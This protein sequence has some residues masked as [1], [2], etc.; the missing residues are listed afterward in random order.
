MQGWMENIAAAAPT[1][2]ETMWPSSYSLEPEANLEGGGTRLIWFNCGSGGENN[3]VD[4]G[5]REGP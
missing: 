5:E 2:W 1:L 3:D 4:D